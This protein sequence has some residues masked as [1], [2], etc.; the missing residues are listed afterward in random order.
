[1]NWSCI[2]RVHR[3]GGHVCRIVMVAMYALH[4][5]CSTQTDH[6]K[7]VPTTGVDVSPGTADRAGIRATDQGAAAAPRSHPQRNDHEASTHRRRPR[8]STRRPRGR[9]DLL[10]K[11][12]TLHSEH[13]DHAFHSEHVFHTCHSEH[14]FHLEHAFLFGASLSHATPDPSEAPQSLAT[15]SRHNLSPQA[16]TTSVRQR[17]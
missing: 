15:V 4:L 1:M 14:V 3:H 10:R 17:C 6:T 11:R 13:S 2:L 8:P 16:L 5:K 7:H 9:L 12:C